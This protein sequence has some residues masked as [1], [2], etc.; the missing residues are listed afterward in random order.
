MYRVSKVHPNI[1]Y[2]LRTTC[3]KKLEFLKVLSLFF[4]AIKIVYFENAAPLSAP[5]NFDQLNYSKLNI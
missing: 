1:S 4:Y 5:K 2:F 3:A